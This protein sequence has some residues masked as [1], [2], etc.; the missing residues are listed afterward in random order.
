MMHDETGRP[1]RGLI[2]GVIAGVV[3][4][5]CC[6]GPAVAALTG[7]TSA[8]VAIDAANFLY[9]QWGWA[10]KLA[11]LAS[12]VVAV[13]VAVRARRRSRTRSLGLL[14]YALIVA[15]TGTLTYGIL[16]G[17]TTWLGGLGDA[18]AVTARS[19]TSV[20]NGGHDR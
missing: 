11:G 6:V 17:L 10:F 2:A 15:L 7:I 20:S 8:A 18:E 3:G 14:R 19:R 1:G 5:G 9:A 13:A 12:A 4:I 16:Y